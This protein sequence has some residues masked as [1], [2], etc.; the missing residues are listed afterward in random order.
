MNKW[1]LPLLA[2]TIG[3][4]KPAT[5]PLRAPKATSDF[6]P[7]MKELSLDDFLGGVSSVKI[8]IRISIPAN[9]LPAK[10]PNGPALTSYW[11]TPE[12]A[13]QARR[14]DDLPLDSGWIYGEFS[15]G[16][17]Y[18]QQARSFTG[19]DWDSPAL[20]QGGF[21]VS[22]T[23]SGAA[24]GYPVAFVEAYHAPTRRPVY[25][26]YVATLNGTDVLV[27]SYRPPHNSR[28]VGDVVW[29][30]LKRSVGAAPPETGVERVK[31]LAAAALHN[32][33]FDLLYYPP[34]APSDP[35]AK[36]IIEALRKTGSRGVFAVIGSDDATRQKEIIG[37]ICLKFTP[38]RLAGAKIAVVGLQEDRAAL[39]A[40]VTGTGAA[41]IFIELK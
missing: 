25:M 27:I 18:D 5:A 8:P 13:A 38:D 7:E 20:A 4:G 29:T 16:V 28:A 21:K 15:S 3:C 6:L 40:L 41:F 14:T 17:A 9:Y 39:E 31:K 34:G 33:E 1:L 2:M 32:E 24:N 12:G 19:L 26:M 23:S 10:L 11:M 30:A 37:K 35:V 22:G 36:S